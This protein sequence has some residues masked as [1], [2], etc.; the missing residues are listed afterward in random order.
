MKL[1]PLLWIDGIIITVAL[2]G[3]AVGFYIERIA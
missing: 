2:I 1:K 3:V